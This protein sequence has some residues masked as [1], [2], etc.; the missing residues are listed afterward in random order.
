MNCDF[1]SY[2]RLNIVKHIGKASNNDRILR[3]LLNS[4]DGM[5]G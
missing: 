3:R 4:I 2:M 1:C 5:C